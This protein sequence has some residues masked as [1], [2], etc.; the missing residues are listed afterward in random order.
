MPETT[1][2]NKKLSFR[3]ATFAGIIFFAVTMTFSATKFWAKAEATAKALADDEQAQKRRLNHAI[4]KQDF[5]TK[6]L[7]LELEIKECKNK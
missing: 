4:E 7:F 3:T 1:I 5:K 2:D 6:I